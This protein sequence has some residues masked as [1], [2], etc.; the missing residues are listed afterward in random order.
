[1]KKLL[2][3][4]LLAAPICAQASWTSTVLACGEYSPMLGYMSAEDLYVMV[5]RMEEVQ[6]DGAQEA[7]ADVVNNFDMSP[8]TG[9]AVSGVIMLRK[10]I[11]GGQLRLE[12][13]RINGFG[14]LVIKPE[15]G[16]ETQV[17][18]KCVKNE[19]VL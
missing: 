14:S 16:K 6:R 4:A 17:G 5:I 15:N 19:P 3:A 18:I 7:I 12:L 2:L 10:H 13:D 11:N 9:T 8:L 1:M